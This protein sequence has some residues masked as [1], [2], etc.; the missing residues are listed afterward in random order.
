[1]QLQAFSPYILVE[2]FEAVWFEQAFPGFLRLRSGQAPRLRAIESD[3]NGNQ[4][5]RSG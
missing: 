2:E 3:M 1:M 4:A 5:L